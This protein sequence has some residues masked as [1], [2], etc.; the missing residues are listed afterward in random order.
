[1]FRGPRAARILGEALDGLSPHH[2]MPIADATRLHRLFVELVGLLHGVRRRQGE[3]VAALER[4]VAA[5]D[6]AARPTAPQAGPVEAVAAAM[7]RRP[8]T[9]WDWAAEARA[10][11]LS[12][13][14]FRRVFRAV[15]GAPLPGFSM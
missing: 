15:V 11:G 12:E 8:F 7:A 3:A 10:I 14:H 5:V 9:A 13:A 6:E 1:M 4:L 2:A